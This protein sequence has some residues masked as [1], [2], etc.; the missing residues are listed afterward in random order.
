MKV[1]VC[2][3]CVEYLQTIETLLEQYKESISDVD[4]AVEKYLDATVLYNKILVG[5]QA[6]IYILDMIMSDRSGLDIGSLIRQADGDGVIIYITSS[7]DYALEAYG[8]HA[9]R[10]LLKPVSEETFF[11]AM[12]FARSYT[13]TRKEHLFPIKT[14]EGTLSVSYSRI[15]YIENYSRTLNVCLDDGENIRSIFIRKSFD[16]EIREIA[17]DRSFLQVHKSFLIN[18]E[19]V[20]KLE[21]SEIVMESGKRIPVSKTRAADVRR[22]YLQFLSVCYQ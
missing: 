5:E 4:F 19:H 1:V 17:G 18:M 7:D 15:E 21:Q 6:D 14:K 10:Y 13:G 11:E 20:K 2:D 9:A 3:D 8:V 16:E 12:N 22:A